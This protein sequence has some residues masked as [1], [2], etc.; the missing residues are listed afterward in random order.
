MAELPVGP[1]LLQPVLEVVDTRPRP[2]PAPCER[3]PAAPARPGAR[4]R[5]SRARRR[6]G[7]RT[8]RET[9]S[10][11]SASTTS[12]GDKRAR[13]RRRTRRRSSRRAP[14]APPR[15]RPRASPQQRSAPRRYLTTP[16]PQRWANCRC[17]APVVARAD[18][19]GAWHRGS[20]CANLCR[21][22]EFFGGTVDRSV[23][24][25][26]CLWTGAGLV[27]REAAEAC[28]GHICR[29]GMLWRGCL[30]PL[31]DESRA[32]L[33]TVS[34]AGYMRSLSASTSSTNGLVTL[35]GPYRRTAASPWYQP[36]RASS[37][38]PPKTWSRC[39]R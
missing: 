5:R 2:A 15:Q 26:Y 32:M 39:F 14:G 6:R 18:M 9:G 34:S 10:P 33:S 16:M 22:C 37:S 38:L 20:N 3:P 24:S 28:L 36:A 11:G 8:P 21:K 7:R 30:A 25:F 13:G 29:G 23:R 27:R 35:Y 31:A 4:R 1:A 17:Q 19:S 12:E